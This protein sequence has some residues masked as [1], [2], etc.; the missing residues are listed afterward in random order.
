MAREIIFFDD[1]VGPH[2]FEQRLFGKK[3]AAVLHENE[4]HFESLRPQRN[5]SSSLLQQTP[6]RIEHVRS[7]RVETIAEYIWGHAKSRLETP[8]VSNLYS[9]QQVLFV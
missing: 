8:I 9:A 2:Q 6:D 3:F 4:K 7:E 1:A 5:D